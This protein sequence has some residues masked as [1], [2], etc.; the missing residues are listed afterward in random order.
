M[1]FYPNPAS[2]FI[3]VEG[4]S[5]SQIEIYSLTG[6]LLIKSTDK[7]INIEHLPAGIYLVRTGGINQR[8]I[9]L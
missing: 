6:S 3:T 5:N 9:K 4:V 2:S 8:L 1:S 7:T